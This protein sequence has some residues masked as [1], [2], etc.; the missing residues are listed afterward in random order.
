MQENFIKKTYK[1]N[2]IK[3]VCVTLICATQMRASSVPITG[4]LSSF[5]IAGLGYGQAQEGNEKADA[6][7]NDLS[8][9]NQTRILN[10]FLMHRPNPYEVIPIKTILVMSQL[11]FTAAYGLQYI[12]KQGSV[13]VAGIGIVLLGSG[14]G[15]AYNHKRQ[16]DLA[17]Q[18]VSMITGVERV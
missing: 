6:F 9:R 13:V 17:M 3:L 5:A 11:A 1:K 7:E 4:L 15:L 8:R 16:V 14:I 10:K 2:I 12:D 18:K